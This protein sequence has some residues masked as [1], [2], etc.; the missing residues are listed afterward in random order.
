MSEEPKIP[1]T[2]EA[3]KHPCAACGRESSYLLGTVRG[4]EP[5]CCRHCEAFLRGETTTH[6]GSA[7]KHDF[8]GEEHIFIAFES[9]SHVPFFVGLG[10]SHVNSQVE[11]DRAKNTDPVHGYP[12]TYYITGPWVPALH[13]T[14]EAA[15]QDSPPFTPDALLELAARDYE[16]VNRPHRTNE[17][18]TDQEKREAEHVRKVLL[19]A[20]EK[21]LL[22]KVAAA[23]QE[24]LDNGRL[25]SPTHGSSD[26]WVARKALH[27]ALATWRNAKTE[28][29]RTDNPR[30]DR[31]VTDSEPLRKVAELAALYLHLTGEEPAHMDMG[32]RVARSALQTAVAEV[33]KL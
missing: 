11:T 8:S 30:N 26:N 2:A 24:Y 21:V 17:A 10:M 29:P 18:F 19:F 15:E 12:Y 31:G 9:I 4:T 7:P 20:A 6:R 1:R 13:R 16:R 32:M 27:N 25:T 3:P 28:E 33:V 22:E 14:S 5:C 23:A